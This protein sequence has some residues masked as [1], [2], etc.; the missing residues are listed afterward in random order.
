MSADLSKI[1]P[2]KQDLEN[3][4]AENELSRE[5]IFNADET[6]LLWRSLPSRSLCHGGETE[7]KNF[8]KA[9]D[10]VSLMACAN[11]TG[12]CKLPLVLIHTAKKPRCFAHMNMDQLPLSYCHQ[13]NSWMDS[14][15]FEVWFHEKF[16]PGVKAFCQKAQIPYKGLLLI[17]NA[18]SHPATSKL[19]SR[20]GKVTTIFLPPNTTSVIHPR[21]QGVL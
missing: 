16:V 21:D 10:R 19:E 18:P 2:F 14:A 13:K 5:H 3:F 4:I 17:D 12:T 6:G 8:K 1:D 7:A 15:I 11:A 9:K 20:D